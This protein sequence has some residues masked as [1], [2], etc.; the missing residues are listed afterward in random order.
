MTQVGTDGATDIDKC[1]LRIM[2]GAATVAEVR[3]DSL[4]G[5]PSWSIQTGDTIID[6]D[7]G[8]CSWSEDGNEGTATFKIRFEGDCSQYDDLELSV[9]VEDD[10]PESAGWTEK[11]SNYFDVI[12]RLVTVSF[13]ATDGRISTPSRLP[14]F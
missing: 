4:T 12:T 3:A 6:L 2:N 11:Q 1:Y 9:Y 5:T 7:T 14:R 13:A 10:E 8:S